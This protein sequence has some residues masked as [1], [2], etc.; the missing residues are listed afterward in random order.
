MNTMGY[1]VRLASGELLRVAAGTMLTSAH[2][3]RLLYGAADLVWVDERGRAVPL[4][5]LGKRYD[6]EEETRS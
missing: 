4:D 5:M 6:R 2:A 1:A 3:D